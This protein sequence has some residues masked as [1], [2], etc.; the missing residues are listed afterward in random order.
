MR[1]RT[2]RLL[3]L[4]TLAAALP[5]AGCGSSIPRVCHV[6]PGPGPN[7]VYRPAGCQH[8]L[9]HETLDVESTPAP[10]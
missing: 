5:L 2:V 3:T 6:Y 4:L 1:T 7:L 10:G 9:K 8:H